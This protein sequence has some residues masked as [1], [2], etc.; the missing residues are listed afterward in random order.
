MHQI[1]CFHLGVKGL[2]R[3]NE[4]KILLLER[5]HP[6]AKIYWDIPGG[7][8]HKGEMPLDT[9]RREVEEETGLK[10]FY[11]IQPFSLELTEIRIPE[12][13]TDVGLIF[14]IFLC[15]IKVPFD[16]KLSREHKTY[17][18]FPP[19]EAAEKLI[20]YPSEFLIRLSN[21]G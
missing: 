14:S 6:S 9:L 20:Q 3:N 4:R 16:P 5:N 19:F 7:R 2:I 10:E 8:L 12:G 21:L 11:R 15:D 18:W 17:G 1:D 13:H